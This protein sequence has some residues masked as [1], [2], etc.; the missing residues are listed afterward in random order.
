[1]YLKYIYI[2]HK[3]KTK[4]WTTR[5]LYTLLNIHLQTQNKPENLYIYNTSS[6]H[7]DQP[8]FDVTIRLTCRDVFMQFDF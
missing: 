2:T 1:M 7:K 5:T 4:I 6:T 3:N 8:T